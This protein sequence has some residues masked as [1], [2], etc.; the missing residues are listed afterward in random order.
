[1]AHKDKEIARLNGVYADMLKA[2][3]VDLVLGWGSLVARPRPLP[4]HRT[5][6]KR[7]PPPPPPLQPP[8]QS[9]SPSRFQPQSPALSVPM[10]FAHSCPTLRAQPNTPPQKDAPHPGKNVSFPPV[11]PISSPTSSFVE[12]H[13]P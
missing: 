6:P 11:P 8:H 5:I 1:M 12:A 4:T 3:G 2:S 10:P 7:Q 9:I 13:L